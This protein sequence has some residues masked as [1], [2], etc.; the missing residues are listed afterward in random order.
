MVLEWT[1]SK[2]LGLANSN[3][4]LSLLQRQSASQEKHGRLHIFLHQYLRTRG[5]EALYKT[6][7]GALSAVTSEES[8]RDSQPPLNGYPSTKGQETS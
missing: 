8:L 7:A 5:Q 6:C 4:D 3:I 2:R 1:L